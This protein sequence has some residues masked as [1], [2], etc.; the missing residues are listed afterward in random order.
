MEST[1]G[2]NNTTIFIND[3]VETNFVLILIVAHQILNDSLCCSYTYNLSL[4][5][6]LGKPD[7]LLLIFLI[8]LSNKKTN[9]QTIIGK[10]YH[11]ASDI[12]D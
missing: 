10:K 1:H 7:I 2:F 5:R 11:F 6:L 9:K 8:N 4:C 12:L 3:D